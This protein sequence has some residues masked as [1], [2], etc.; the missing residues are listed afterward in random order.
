M[1]EPLK[2]MYNRSFFQKIAPVLKEVIT[3]YEHQKFV[4]KIFDDAWDNLELKQR[5]RHITLCLHAFM[6]A[7]YAKAVPVLIKLSKKFRQ[8]EY[9]EQS[10]PLI[11]LADYIEV[12]GV[13]H[14][15]DSIKAMEEITQLVSAEF[16]VR[17]FLTKYYEKMMAQMLRWSKHGEASVRRL[18]SEGFG[19]CF[20]Y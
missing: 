2:N 18:S 20:G 14:V 6:P 11:F 3:G 17:P 9:R 19:V 10:F 12:F 16:A 8:Y 15:D 7:D 5:V 4:K 1:A 13:D